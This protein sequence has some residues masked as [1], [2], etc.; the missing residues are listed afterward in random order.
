MTGAHTVFYSWQDDIPSKD[1]RSFIEQASAIN[2]LAQD[3]TL[4]E[5][6]R[7]EGLAMDKD[8]AGVAGSP[9]IFDTIFRK[10]DAAAA[11]TM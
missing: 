2:Q 3:V 1:C 10:I 9:P 8:T 4:D 7:Q 6:V 5:A 11:S